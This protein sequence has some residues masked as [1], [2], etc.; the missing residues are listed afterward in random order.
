MTIHSR[1]AE[2]DAEQA[3]ITD[4]VIVFAQTFTSPRSPSAT[5]KCFITI[6]RRRSQHFEII[7]KR[8]ALD[9]SSLKIKKYAGEVNPF[10]MQITTSHHRIRGGIIFPV[11]LGESF[12]EMPDSP[13]S[14][15]VVHIRWSISEMEASHRS[16][17]RQVRQT[18]EKSLTSL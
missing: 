15:A 1:E 16:L 12:V 11:Y 5:L 18:P 10:C 17:I 9:D 8:S 14:P 7:E 4:C 3:L 2:S 13:T 6:G